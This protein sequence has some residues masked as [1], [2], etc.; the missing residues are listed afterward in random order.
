MLGSNVSVWTVTVPRPH[1]DITKSR[2]QLSQF[3]TI[4]RPLLDRIKAAHGQTTPLHVFPAAPTSLAIEFGRIRMP[5]A[6]MPWRIY[7][8]VN[9]R[10]GFVPALSIPCGD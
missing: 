5:K 9:A 10:G 3:R 2:T 4:L 7:D 1:N 6:D 8:Q